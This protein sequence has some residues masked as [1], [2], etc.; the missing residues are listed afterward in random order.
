[1]SGHGR[2]FLLSSNRGAFQAVNES[3]PLT[4]ED[5]DAMLKRASTAREMLTDCGMD[6]TSLDD[7]ERLVAE[8]RRLRSQSD[9]ASSL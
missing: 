3:K 2:G 8:V 4:A 9:R 5:L 1:M 7:V 6:V